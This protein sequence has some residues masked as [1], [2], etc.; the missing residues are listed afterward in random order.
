MASFNKIIVVGHLGRDPVLRYTP[1]GTAV[2]DFSLATT[3]RRAGGG[4]GQDV[5]TWFKVTLWGKQAEV[6]NQYLA[7]GRQVYVEGRLR[8]TEYTDKEGMKRTSLE[9]NATDIQF[10]GTR[11]EEGTAPSASARPAAAARPQ[12]SHDDD[13][14]PHD[15]DIPF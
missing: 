7:K 6:A 5:T 2:C 1:Q 4:D 3:E 11:G 14:Q 10:L 15:D 9:V 8:Q 12:Q 13:H